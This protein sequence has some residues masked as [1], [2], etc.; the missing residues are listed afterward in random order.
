VAHPSGQN[1]LIQPSIRVI[2]EKSARM[3]VLI[4]I[5]SI[6]VSVNQAL[7]ISRR[8]KSSMLCRMKE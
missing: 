1:N 5:R 7:L 6:D 3:V 4:P 8:R 2:I